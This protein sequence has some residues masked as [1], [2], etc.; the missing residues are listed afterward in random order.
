MRL[1]WALVPEFFIQFGKPDEFK[2]TRSGN[3]IS[4]A[5][6]NKP[7]ALYRLAKGR[8]LGERMWFQNEICV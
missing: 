6:D 8:P 5:T 2:V 7:R 3:F 1:F 4:T